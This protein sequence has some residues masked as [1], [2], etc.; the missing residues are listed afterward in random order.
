MEPCTVDYPDGFLALEKP[1][2]IRC[3]PGAPRSLFVLASL[4]CM[5]LAAPVV[6]AQNAVGTVPPAVKSAAEI[7]PH[8]AGID[9]FINKA[10]AQLA[11]EDPVAQAKARQA[12]ENEARLPGPGGNNAATPAYLDLYAQLLAQA[13]KPLTTN[14]SARVRLNAAIAAAGVAQAVNNTHLSGVAL[15]FINDKSDAVVLWG[16][17]AARWIIPAQLRAALADLSLVNAIVPAVKAHPNGVIGGAIVVE[18]YDALVLDI[19][20][21]KMAITP[22]M[23]KAT[24][25]QVLALLKTRLEQYRLGVPPTP[26]AEGIGSGFLSHR[27][28]WTQ[29]TPAQQLDVMQTLCDL[30]A[31]AA[32]QAVAANKG[33]L[34]DLIVMIARVASAISINADP[35]VTAKLQPA[36]VVKNLAEIQASVPAILPTLRGLAPYK[37]LKDPPAVQDTRPAPAPASAPTT[38]PV[39]IPGVTIIAP[40]IPPGAGLPAP[41]TGAPA[42]GAGPTAGPGNTTPGGTRPPASGTQRPA[43]GAPANGTPA[44]PG[45]GAPAAPG[46]AAPKQAPANSARPA[47][48]AP[49]GYPAR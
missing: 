30:L 12:I 46:A 16:L 42:P 11:G 44:A 4:V 40:S 1:L 31:L 10:V 14:P 19:F 8:R 13:L 6:C 49:K 5:T 45:S 33:D 21:R 17:K 27:D 7:A 47:S 32:Q 36:T 48:P 15:A 20:G 38:G 24:A 29:L 35:S 2:M 28:V 37:A 43:T 39:T 18:A 3:L 9:G 25:P 22:V 41:G 26:R 23:L 34:T